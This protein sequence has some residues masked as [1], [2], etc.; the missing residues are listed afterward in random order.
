[1]FPIIAFSIIAVIVVVLL[2]T[3]NVRSVSRGQLTPPKADPPKEIKPLE[4]PIETVPLPVNKESTVG[5]M[6]DKDYRKSL[7]QFQTQASSKTP[8]PR[9][10][11]LKDQEY[12]SVLRSMNK[13]KE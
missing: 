8:E 13:P 2:L 7:Q 4:N 6:L 5:H 3:Y 1:M 10:P 12:R 11:H 9:K